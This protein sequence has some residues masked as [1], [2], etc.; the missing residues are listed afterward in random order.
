MQREQNILGAKYGNEKKAEWMNN[1]KKIQGLE[2]GPDAK[3]PL[4][5][6]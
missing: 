3:I 5:L 6:L 4:D 2:E 1:M